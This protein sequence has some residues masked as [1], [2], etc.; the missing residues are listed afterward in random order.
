M[1]VCTYVLLYICKQ[2]HCLSYWHCCSVNSNVFNGCTYLEVWNVDTTACKTILKWATVYHFVSQLK[3]ESN[4]FKSTFEW[5]AFKW[6]LVVLF[7]T[8]IYK[9]HVQIIFKI[10]PNT[11]LLIYLTLPFGLFKKNRKLCTTVQLK[12]AFKC[13]VTHLIITVYVNN[14]FWVR[15][16]H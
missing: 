6:A 4:A 16:G 15:T 9:I 10:N 2:L 5:W 1:Y 7:P 13:P 11:L 14:V 3:I 8:N 12:H